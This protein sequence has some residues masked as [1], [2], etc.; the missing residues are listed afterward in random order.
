MEIKKPCG[1]QQ[2]KIDGKYI[3]FLY[4]L[5]SLAMH[6]VPKTHAALRGN[7]DSEFRIRVDHVYSLLMQMFLLAF[8][9]NFEK[10]PNLK[11]TEK[12]S[13][14]MFIEQAKALL[15]DK[16]KFIMKHLNDQVLQDS[17]HSMVPFPTMLGFDTLMAALQKIAE[18][19]YRKM[20]V[21]LNSILMSDTIVD[22]VKLYFVRNEVF[23]DIF[24]THV[25][26]FF[27]TDL[28]VA[29]QMTRQ[30]ERLSNL[31][32]KVVSTYAAIVAR[33]AV[34]FTA[35]LQPVEQT[36]VSDAPQSAPPLVDESVEIVRVLPDPPPRND[37]TDLILAVVNDALNSCVKNAVAKAAEAFD[38]GNRSTVMAISGADL[39][40]QVLAT[41]VTSRVNEQ[42]LK[43]AKTAFAALEVIEAVTAAADAGK[44]LFKENAPDLGSLSD[45]VEHT[46]AP[47]PVSV[48]NIPVES[49][50]NSP[51]SSATQ[52]PA[53]AIPGDAESAALFAAIS[54][55]NQPLSGQHQFA[56]QFH[57]NG[58]GGPLSVI[59]EED[60]DCADQ[61]GNS[62]LPDGERRA[63]FTTAAQSPPKGVEDRA[64]GAQHPLFSSIDLERS[65]DVPKSFRSNSG[66]TL[67][68]G[69][70]GTPPT[71]ELSSMLLA[72]S[73]PSSPQSAFTPAAVTSA[74]GSTL[75]QLSS[76]PL[77]NAPKP[78]FKTDV[79]RW[80]MNSGGSHSSGIPIGNPPGNAK[81]IV[82][83]RWNPHTNQPSF[84]PQGNGEPPVQVLA[85]SGN[86]PS[87][88]SDGADHLETP[89][90]SK[91]WR[92]C[93]PGRKTSSA[94]QP[95]NSSS[96]WRKIFHR[97]SNRVNPVPGQTN[98]ARPQVAHSPGKNPSESAAAP[99]LSPQLCPSGHEKGVSNLVAHSPDKISSGN[100]ATPALSPQMCPSGHEKGGIE[101]N[102]VSPQFMDH[103][104]KELMMKYSTAPWT[105]NPPLQWTHPCLH[106]V[107]NLARFA[108]VA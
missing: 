107:P 70:S 35:E 29:N 51:A 26:V 12:S 5:R 86:P 74:D 3:R 89:S 105:C 85:K 21:P 81:S 106:R 33:T 61:S 88:D 67:S 36:F 82:G 28:K 18:T 102:V 14:K 83:V 4:D 94:S 59:P 15:K 6:P 37:G 92:S 24:V 41:E 27:R 96:S 1:Q 46:Q 91:L 76:K 72:A 42:A 10:N 93:I 22:A 40:A 63:P 64:T 39:D 45:S 9:K 55:S 32:P 44:S 87:G 50:T 98:D 8:L 53:D 66:I 62:P 73:M 84:S 48:V 54:S 103:S 104:F 80:K 101:P 97:R 57:A 56:P 79:V 13:L 2:K 7:P 17:F 58:A 34:T 25:W 31:P 65:V 23:M 19:H 69:P 75:A 11:E 38:A 108:S 49:D 95:G 100:A 47:S 30:F 90:S 68:S 16:W 71:H 99:A 77:K 52:L 78:P 43:A 60:E 20:G